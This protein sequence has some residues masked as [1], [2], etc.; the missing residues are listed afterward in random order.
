MFF[1]MICKSSL[2]K[3]H[4]GSKSRSLG[5]IEG[6]LVNTLEAAFFASEVCLKDIK[7]KFE[8]GSYWVRN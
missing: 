3:G 1:L 6:N 2:I 5:Q 7:V 4:V 8:Y